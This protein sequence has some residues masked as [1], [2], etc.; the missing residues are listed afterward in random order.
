MSW[1]TAVLLTKCLLM[2]C[3]RQNTDL[4]GLGHDAV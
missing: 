3:Q 4:D 1:R 2:P